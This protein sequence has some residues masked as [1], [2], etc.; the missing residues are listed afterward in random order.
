[1]PVAP[2]THSFRVRADATAPATAGAPLAAS[3]A[4]SC[5]SVFTLP[6]LF[7]PQFWADSVQTRG[8]LGQSKSPQTSAVLVEG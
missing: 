7:M 5:V 1:M 4:M 6:P 3:T 2:A 8:R